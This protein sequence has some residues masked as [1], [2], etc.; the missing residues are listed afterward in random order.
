MAGSACADDELA[1]AAAVGDARGVLRR[2]A[3]IMVVVP[4]KD[5]VDAGGV[6]VAPDRAHA[7]RQACGAAIEEWVMPVRDLAGPRMTGEVLTEP[8]LLS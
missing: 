2:E 4:G 3:L 6:Q 7:G 8:P 1:R 5:H